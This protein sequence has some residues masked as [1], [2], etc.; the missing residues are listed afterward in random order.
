MAEKKSDS[1][2]INANYIVA[3]DSESSQYI[4]CQAPLPSTF[5]TFWR[6]IWEHAVPV[7]CMLTR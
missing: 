7:I 1:D 5:A 6:M 4:S 3:N 2:Y